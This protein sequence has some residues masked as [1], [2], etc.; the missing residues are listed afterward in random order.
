MFRLLSILFSKSSLTPSIRHHMYVQSQFRE[1]HLYQRHFQLP[2]EARVVV[3][4]QLQTLSG[5]AKGLTRATDSSLGF[6]ESPQ[7]KAEVERMQRAREDVRMIKLRESMFSLIRSAVDLWST[8]ASITGVCATTVV[9]SRSLIFF[10]TGPQRSF[11][12]DNMST[13]GYHA[14][15]SPRW[16]PTGIGLSRITTPL[17]SYMVVACGHAFCPVEPSVTFAPNPQSR[18]K[19]GSSCDRVQCFPHSSTSLVIC[20]GSAWCH[21]GC[22][23]KIPIVLLRYYNFFYRIL[24]LFKIFSV[25]WKW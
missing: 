21:G 5:V 15:I 9:P 24:I 4:M 11:Q 8:D 16:S 3:H 25:V 19:R 18:S 17:D 6:D 23:Y 13:S 22:T 10:Y 7:E 20:T 2:D 14:H 12:I 1:Y